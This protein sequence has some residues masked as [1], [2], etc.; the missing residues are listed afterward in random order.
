MGKARLNAVLV[1]KRWDKLD[2][3]ELPTEKSCRKLD[4]ILEQ[5]VVTLT[6]AQPVKKAI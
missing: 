4:E 6:E 5:K 2:I 1:A 3:A